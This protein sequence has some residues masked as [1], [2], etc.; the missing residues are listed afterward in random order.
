MDPTTWLL[1][2]TAILTAQYITMKISE[3]Q[4]ATTQTTTPQEQQ[5]IEEPEQSIEPIQILEEPTPETPDQSKE[6]EAEEEEK[7]KPPENRDENKEKSPRRPEET[8]SEDLTPEMLQEISARLNELKT[9]LKTS[10]NLKKE[11]EKLASI[12]NP[13]KPGKELIRPKTKIKTTRGSSAW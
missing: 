6:K 5:P 11:L 8:R 3:K 2:A 7:A 1:I 10:Q 13:Q 9:L 4:P 12:L